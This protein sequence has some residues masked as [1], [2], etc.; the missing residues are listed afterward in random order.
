MLSLV[1]CETSFWEI[2]NKMFEELDECLAFIQME[3]KIKLLSTYAFDISLI[4][5]CVH[6]FLYVDIVFFMHL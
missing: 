5:H 2:N 3:Y 6:G 4:S 1:H